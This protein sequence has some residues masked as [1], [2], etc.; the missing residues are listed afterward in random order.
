MHGIS[1]GDENRFLLGFVLWKSP[2]KE[3]NISGTDFKVDGAFELKNWVREDGER[4]GSKVPI[5]GD[6]E[7]RMIRGIRDLG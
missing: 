3:N 6:V 7:G 1:G 4:Y 5:G 2:F